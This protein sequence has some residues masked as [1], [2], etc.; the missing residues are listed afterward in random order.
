MNNPKRLLQLDGNERNAIL[1]VGSYVLDWLVA[2]TFT[3]NKLDALR[4]T[5]S[6]SFASEIRDEEQMRS[7]L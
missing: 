2:N 7:Q 4:M 5:L 1:N 6:L 3:Q